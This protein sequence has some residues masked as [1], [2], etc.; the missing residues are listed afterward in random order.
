MS[1]LIKIMTD[2]IWTA[3]LKYYG[4]TV[5]LS[6][7]LYYINVFNKKYCFNYHNQ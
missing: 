4:W 3:S 1:H 5:S 6:M 2:F 7:L